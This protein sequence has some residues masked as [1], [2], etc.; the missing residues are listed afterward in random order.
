[1]SY[2]HPEREGD[3]T[4]PKTEVLAFKNV[5]LQARDAANVEGL[6]RKDKALAEKAASL[7][8]M[9]GGADSEIRDKTRLIAIKEEAFRD[10]S[11]ISPANQGWY[12]RLL[13]REIAALEAEIAE[14]QKERSEEAKSLSQAR[15]SSLDASI[16]SNRQT[17][18]VKME[19]LAKPEIFHPENRGLLL[20]ILAREI[21][22]LDNKVDMQSK[23][24]W[25]RRQAPPEL[26][27]VLLRKQLDV[28]EAGLAEV[29]LYR[30][31]LSKRPFLAL[32]QLDPVVRTELISAEGQVAAKGQRTPERA[33]AFTGLA[34]KMVD[35]LPPQVQSWLYQSDPKARARDL[36][37]PMLRADNPTLMSLLVHNLAANPPRACRMEL[38]ELVAVRFQGPT[39]SGEISSRLRDIRQRAQALDGLLKEARKAASQA[40]VPEKWCSRLTGE[41]KNFLKTL[42]CETA[43]EVGLDHYTLLGVGSMARDEMLP[44][45]DIDY[46]AILDRNIDLYVYRA[47]EKIKEVEDYC[48]AMLAYIDE[49]KLDEMER[50]ESVAGFFPEALAEAHAQKKMDIIQDAIELASVSDIKLSRDVNRSVEHP[51]QLVIVDEPGG[52]TEQYFACIKAIMNDPEARKASILPFID[53]EADK[54]HPE[55][56]DYMRWPKKDVKKGLLR[57]P[58]FCVRNLVFYYG[59]SDAPQ[60]LGGRC[61]A[62]VDRKLMSE[63]LADKILFVSKFSLDL[64]RKL[65]VHYG[66]ECEDFCLKADAA[67][68]KSAPVKE[69]EPIQD[70][71]EKQVQVYVLDDVEDEMAKRCIAINLDLFNRMKALTKGCFLSFDDLGTWVLEKRHPGG[72]LLD[73]TAVGPR[74]PVVAA[75]IRINLAEALVAGA[76][77]DAYVV[78]QGDNVTK[79]EIRRQSDPAM[80]I[81]LV[82]QDL[83]NR[84]LKVEGKTIMFNTGDPAVFPFL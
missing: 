14:L 46:Q 20:G 55:K 22:N 75:R 21:E 45:S 63:A 6:D 1:M 26:D 54:F 60:D 57:M 8:S 80:V 50:P 11:A 43:H 83:V 71:P 23:Q 30:Q 77:G 5:F 53:A 2:V 64:R 40:E 38:R 69:G 48:N 10:P 68:V 81:A 79:L 51:G 36:I 17:L 65:H 74:Q 59:L 25:A 15:L 73:C 9:L 66:K 7:R 31:I 29:N 12:L 32:D 27:S 42:Y 76:P 84:Q 78:R 34:N 52:I 16:K 19:A 4:G 62:L 82:D 37:E 35:A 18:N 61:K 3:I 28:V 41:Y 33:S 13:Q 72:K 44:Y 70:E 56:S 58:I 47:I 24:A 39:I 49:P 67:K